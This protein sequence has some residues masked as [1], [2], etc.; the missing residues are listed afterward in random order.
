MRQLLRRIRGA[1]GIGVT[2]GVVWSAVG[3]IPRWVFG[4]NTDAPVPLIFGVLGFL[5]G[6]TFAGILAL[7]ERRRRFDEMSIPRFAGWGAAGGLLLSALFAAPASLY[8]GDV[9]AVAPT[10]A[11]ACAICASGSLALARRG[12]RPQLPNGARPK[13]NR[14]SS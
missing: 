2:W 4:V 6:V 3:G 11:I 13:Q 7:A 10:F 5:A 12:E 1:L 14:E 9:L 8:W